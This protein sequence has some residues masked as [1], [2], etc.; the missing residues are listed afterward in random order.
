MHWWHYRKQNKHVTLS[1]LCLESMQKYS[2]SINKIHKYVIINCGYYY[3]RSYRIS[4]MGLWPRF[5][6]PR[7]SFPKKVKEPMGRKKRF[8]L[9]GLAC[10]VILKWEITYIQGKIKSWEYHKTE[11]K[12]MKGVN[13]AGK[14]R[15]CWLQKNLVDHIR[16]FGFYPKSNEKVPKGSTKQKSKSI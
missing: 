6:K 14:G 12:G 13:V 2:Q 15:R 7:E 10:T 4:T 3:V 1:L 8:Q 11:N 5:S 9:Q 16:D